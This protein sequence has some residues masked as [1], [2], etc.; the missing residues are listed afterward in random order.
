M[1]SHT[2]IFGHRVPFVVTNLA[3]T[4]AAN[5]QNLQ[6]HL[7]AWVSV[8]KNR[9]KRP[10]DHSGLHKIVYGINRMIAATKPQLQYIEDLFRDCGYDTHK[11]R[12]VFLTV[13]CKRQVDTSDELSRQEA[14]QILVELIRIK[15]QLQKE[16]RRD[17]E[18]E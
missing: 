6:D 3:D 7:K 18:F 1:H 9:A 16:S 2:V 4:N 12:A 10:Q 5:G 13:E 14:S 15:Q 11:K 17:A 8:I